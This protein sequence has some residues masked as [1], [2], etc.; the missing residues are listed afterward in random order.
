MTARPVPAMASREGDA[1]VGERPRI[2]DH[3]VDDSP[4]VVEPTHELALGVRLEVDDGDVGLRGVSAQVGED[5]IEGVVTVDLRFTGAEQV[6]VRSVE[7]EHGA[8]HESRNCRR[9]VGHLTWTA[10]HD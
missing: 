5:V 10:T 7:D 2:E 9:P 1:V 8:R 4:R 3:S 6:E